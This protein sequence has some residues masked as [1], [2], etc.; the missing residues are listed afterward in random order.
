ML[1]MGEILNATPFPD[2]KA[3]GN[4]ELLLAF[5]Q[6]ANHYEFISAGLRNGDFDERMVRDSERSS[7]VALFAKSEQY[8]RRLRDSRARG[9]IY[10]HLEWLHDRWERKRPSLI[11]RSIEWCIGR[12]LPGKRANTH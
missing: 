4:E 11:Q 10:E 12:P 1:K 3:A 2:L 5:R 9:A 7:I 8:I 6:V